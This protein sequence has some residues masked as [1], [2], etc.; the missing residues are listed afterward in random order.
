ESD[1]HPVF[2][3]GSIPFPPDGAEISGAKWFAPLRALTDEDV[4][5]ATKDLY[6]PYNEA[7]YDENRAAADPDNVVACSRCL[8]DQG[9][10]FCPDVG[11]KID[12]AN[13]DRDSTRHHFLHKFFG[14]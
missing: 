4:W 10:V 6:I 14:L 9:R 1:R 12:A 2:D 8:T 7:K 11:R 5:Q 13:W 3:D